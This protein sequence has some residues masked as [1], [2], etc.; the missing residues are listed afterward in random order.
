MEEPLTEELLDELLSASSPADFS[1]GR[2]FPFS[3]ASEYLAHLLREKGLKRSEVV[4]ASGLNST[5]G[6][7]IFTGARNASRDK[8]L[9]LA[10]AMSLEQHETD[11][12]LM[13]AGH[14]PLYVKLRRDA[15][16]LFCMQRGFTFAQTEETLF[17][18]GEKTIA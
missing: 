3:S 16:I 15:I 14:S 9:Q 1:D 6:Y 5:F 17:R 8:L 7:Q 10:F 11:R 18:F 2:N 13:L 12:L 4:A